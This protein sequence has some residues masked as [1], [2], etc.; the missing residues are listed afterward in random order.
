MLLKGVPSI[1]M[2][3]CFDC[4]IDGEIA[5]NARV[6]LNLMMAA[7]LAVSAF[8]GSPAAGQSCGCTH[9]GGSVNCPAG[10][11]PGSRSVQFVPGGTTWVTPAGQNVFVP[12]TTFSCTPAPSTRTQQTSPLQTPIAPQ[13]DTG[14]A[15]RDRSHGL[16]LIE[17]L[18]RE[19]E[20]R[21]HDSPASMPPDCDSMSCASHLKEDPGIV[22]YRHVRATL[23]D[24]SGVVHRD[25]LYDQLVQASGIAHAQ[26]GST[27]DGASC[28]GKAYDCG[29]TFY[30]RDG[31]PINVPA[32][33]AR[34][35]SDADVK[36]W[37]ANVQ[38]FYLGAYLDPRGNNK[39]SP[40][41]AELCTTWAG[42][43]FQ[44]RPDPSVSQALDTLQQVGGE[45]VVGQDTTW[46]THIVDKGTSK[47]CPVPPVLPQHDMDSWAV[48]ESS[49]GS[50]LRGFRDCG[51]PDTS[52]VGGCPHAFDQGN[53]NQVNAEYLL[54]ANTMRGVSAALFI[55]DEPPPCGADCYRQTDK[56]RGET[57]QRSAAPRDRF[58]S[59]PQSTDADADCTA[60]INTC[61][62]TCESG[63][64]AMTRKCI[65]LGGSSVGG[66]CS[67]KTEG[68]S[69]I[70]T[71]PV[72][73]LPPIP[74]GT[75]R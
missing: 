24:G 63:N 36:D 68:C 53:G 38:Q 70:Q 43:Y 10:L 52:R 14:K 59:T 19:I 22:C 32:F 71:S 42:V 58:V 35:S 27:C 28:N 57:G 56:P 23:K 13:T 21:P 40:G 18:G 7:A 16:G 64:A 29:G 33:P 4:R 50:F 45:K 5:V 69:C 75:D 6:L 31:K 73:K 48:P 12:Q 60:A 51:K 49:A 3:D 74:S 11:P 2:R 34:A 46:L 41:K 9:Q 72:C 37:K 8:S 30:D 65:E 15:T 66:S 55:V 62:Q 1:A 44:A 54:D 26:I 39:L 47:G 61:M 20:R 17:Q 67:I 25:S